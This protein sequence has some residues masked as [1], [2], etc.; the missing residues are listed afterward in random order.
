[1]T[2]RGLS[3]KSVGNFVA[4]NY[5]KLPTIAATAVD[6]VNAIKGKNVTSYVDQAAKN[7]KDASDNTRVVKGVVIFIGAIAGLFLLIFLMRRR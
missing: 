6:T 1:M 5:E 4:K 3:L 2:I 7:V